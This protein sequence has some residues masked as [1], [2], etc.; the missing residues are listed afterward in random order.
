MSARPLALTHNTLIDGTGRPPLE[1][2]VL[3]LRDGRVEAIA[4]APQW[5]PPDGEPMSI[6][7]LSGHTVLPGLI[8]RLV[9]LAMDGRADS[10]L[11]GEAPWTT[12]LMLK[13]A[14]NHLAA[15][16][17]TVRDVGGRSGSEFSVRRALEQ[18]LWGRAAHATRGHAA[19]DHFGGRDLL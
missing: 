11:D 16:F 15:G 18:G 10:K 2:A 9:H 8:D 1:D 12:P 17:T 19:L 7:D 13:R 3:V 6:L 4:P 5:Q 14:Q